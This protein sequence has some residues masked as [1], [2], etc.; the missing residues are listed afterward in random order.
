[1][2]GG[3]DLALRE[4]LTWLISEAPA[5]EGFRFFHSKNA[6][7]NEPD[8]IL[9][10]H[11]RNSPEYLYCFKSWVNFEFKYFLTDFSVMLWIDVIMVKKTLS[12]SYIF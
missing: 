12:F 6:S 11:V 3:L 10:N 1:M 4:R 9:A 2:K 8:G 5:Q 7:F